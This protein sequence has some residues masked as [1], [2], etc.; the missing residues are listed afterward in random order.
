MNEPNKNEELVDFWE[1]E[2]I[3]ETKDEAPTELEEEENTSEEEREEESTKDESTEP[4]E[5]D[6]TDEPTE[7]E[8]PEEELPF[9]EVMKRRFGY[10]DIEDEF[11]D[12]EDGL[13]SLTQKA[14][15]RMA[16]DYMDQMYTQNPIMKDFFE[17]VENGGDP[18][19]FIGVKFPDMDY[20]KMEFDADNTE[21]QERLVKEE[22][23]ASGYSGEE[24]NAELEDIKNGGILENK[25]RRALSRLKAKQQSEQEGLVEQQREQRRIQEQQAKEAWE[26]VKQTVKSSRSLKDIPLPEA[27]KSP[28]LDYL[29]KPVKDG[30]SQRDLDLEAV[31]LE[32]TLLVDYLLYKKFSLAGLVDRRAK[33]TTAK[34]L[35][36]RL[37]AAKLDKK[38]DVSQSKGSANEELGTL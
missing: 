20:S 34:G 26:E 5:T 11:N 27:D 17:Y 30:K 14:A 29:M 38:E 35:R 23:V 15:E 33:T 1:L 10:E 4:T 25:A 31:G 24:V 12:D 8:T 7:E 37:K 32:E 3:E 2:E 16:S 9:V 36:E 28:F 13:I 6:E 18:K 19:H 21:L 22:L